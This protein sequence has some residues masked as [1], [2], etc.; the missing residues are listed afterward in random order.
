VVWLGK[1]E[2]AS[3][4]EPLSSLPSK[5]VEEY[6]AGFQREVV[7]EAFTSAG[8]TLHTLSSICN[9]EARSKTKKPRI[10]E[11]ST[12]S[13]GLVRYHKRLVTP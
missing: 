5:L 12:D 11:P 13:T 10:S 1:P 7:D 9:R 8:Q 4:W 3:T 2:A 6:E